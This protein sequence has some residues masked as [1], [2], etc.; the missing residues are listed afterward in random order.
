ME[1][2]RSD[3]GEGKAEGCNYVPCVSICHKAGPHATEQQSKDGET[4]KGNEYHRHW[5]DEDD[6]GGYEYSPLTA[7]VI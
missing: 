3:T 6:E 1:S 7:R 5:H 2:S 4:A